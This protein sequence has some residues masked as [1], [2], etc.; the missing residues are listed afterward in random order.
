M[1]QF[2]Q[3]ISNHP[4]AAAGVGLLISFIVT[5]ILNTIEKIANYRVYKK[6]EE[7]NEESDSD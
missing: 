1:E 3:S 6:H 4:W 2:L 7:R 5:G